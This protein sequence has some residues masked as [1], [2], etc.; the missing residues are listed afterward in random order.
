MIA[1]DTSDPSVLWRVSLGDL[2]PSIATTTDGTRANVVAHDHF[3]VLDTRS[4]TM[5]VQKAN[6]PS[7]IT[8]NSGSDYQQVAVSGSDDLVVATSISGDF[9]VLNASAF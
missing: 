9:V 8:Y 7:S 4:G 3:W 2:P 6:M 1:I 5:K